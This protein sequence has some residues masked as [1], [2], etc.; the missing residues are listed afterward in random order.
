MAE[1]VIFD[2]VS[3]HCDLELE[4]TNQSSC[5]T[6]WPKMTNHCAKFGYKTFS[7]WGDIAQK[8]NH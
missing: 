3:L 5:M 4:D 7:S 6:L 8:N 1:T 2:Y